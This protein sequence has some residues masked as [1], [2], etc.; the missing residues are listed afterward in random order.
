MKFRKLAALLL[1]LA[2]VLALAVACAPKDEKGDLDYIKSK[3]KMVIGITFFAP[4]DYYDTDNTTL[5]GFDHDLAVAVCDKLGVGAEFQEINWNTKEDELNASTID[6]IWNG[7]TADADRAASMSLSSY[8]MKNRQVVVVKKENAATLNTIEALAGK[9][10]AAEAGSAGEEAIRKNEALKLVS[11]NAQ[12]D[13]LLEVKSGTSDFC[14]IDSVMAKAMTEAPGSDFAD[15]TV[16][17]SINMGDDEFYAIAFRKGSD[18]TAAV[19]EIL[20]EL[21]K[22]GTVAAIAAKYGLTDVLQEIK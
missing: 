16:V 3:G 20:A 8:Y 18:T 12:S 10:G 22:D 21:Y 14:V 9:N 4:M 15:L 13:A 11:V 1:A 2:A 7:L 6:C 19:N 17:D 5:I